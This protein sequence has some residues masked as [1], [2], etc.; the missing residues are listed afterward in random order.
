MKDLKP[1][2]PEELIEMQVPIGTLPTPVFVFPT[3]FFS[4]Y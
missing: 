1:S 2:E 4:V 3:F